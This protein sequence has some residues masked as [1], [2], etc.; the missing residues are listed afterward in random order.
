M[1]VIIPE[2]IRALF[3]A[4]AGG[5]D[6]QQNDSKLLYNFILSKRDSVVKK[7]KLEDHLLALLVFLQAIYIL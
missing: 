5:S 7:K 2:G 4:P 3:T 1:S 6:H